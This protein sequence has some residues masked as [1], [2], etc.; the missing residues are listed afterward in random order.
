MQFALFRR[1]CTDGSSC[2]CCSSEIGYRGTRRNLFAVPIGL[3]TLTTL[4]ASAGKAAT[5]SDTTEAEPHTPEEAIAA[6]MAG[7]QRYVH[8]QLGVCGHDL[9]RVLQETEN[10][11]TPFA[12]VLSCADS[13]VPVQLVFDQGIGR[14]FAT[15]VA[16]NIAAP[17]IIASLEYGVAVLGTRAIVVL[18]HGDCGAVAATMARKAAPGQ[19]SSLYAFIRPAVERADGDLDKAIRTN[20]ALQAQ[21]L[22]RSSPVLAEAISGKKLAIVAGYYDVETGKVT[23]L[24]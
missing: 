10:K 22:A 13:R 23:L 20:A 12:A 19:I 24:N 4:G 17:E 7:N 1:G 21:L 5:A 2:A 6:L 18:G 11:Q 3:A 8:E 14:L 16:G 15:R 9:P